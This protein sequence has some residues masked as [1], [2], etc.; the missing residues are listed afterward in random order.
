[1]EK[2]NKNIIVAIL[3]AGLIVGAGIGFYMAPSDEPVDTSEVD[4][5][6]QKIVQMQE[7][8]MPMEPF[9]LFLLLDSDLIKFDWHSAINE[10]YQETYPL[11]TEVISPGQQGDW[12][13]TVMTAI[14]SDSPIDV[15]LGIDPWQ[16]GERGAYLDLT[17][18]IETYSRKDDVLP[19]LYEATTLD[20]KIYAMPNLALSYQIFYNKNA[21][22]LAGVPH[23]TDPNITWDEFLDLAQALT[24]DFDNDGVIDQY[25]FALFHRTDYRMGGFAAWL[26]GNGGRLWSEDW[27]TPMWNSPEAIETAQYL[28][29]LVYEYEVSPVP[30]AGEAGFRDS[31][32]LFIDGKAAMVISY[33][34]FFRGFG[35][36]NP[37]LIDNWGVIN[38]PYN[39]A[40]VGIMFGTGMTII[41]NSEHPY[42]AWKWIEL[43]NSDKYTLQAAKETAWIPGY[44]SLIDDWKVAEA[45]GDFTPIKELIPTLADASIGQ[46]VLGQDNAKE[47]QTTEY[48]KNAIEAILTQ[49][50]DPKTELDR[51]VA[52]ALESMG[53]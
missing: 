20:G 32:S 37:D 42:A 51:A 35:S 36:G 34:G 21:F 28:Q 52:D 17:P 7:F 27:E 50:A 14:Q 19:G 38:I 22:D 15:A 11:T 8:S 4:E 40:P 31:R 18:Y 9:E 5:L 3:I 24:K 43:Y 25:G 30:T 16:L 2:T 39:E 44:S 26:M 29:D 1:M 46:F 6:K 47:P 48:L 53:G 49:G 45:Y 10:Q 12:V 33:T 13:S 41:S 23:W